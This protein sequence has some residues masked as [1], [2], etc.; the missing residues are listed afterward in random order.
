[1]KIVSGVIISLIGVYSASLYADNNAKF[2]QCAV[3]LCGPTSRYAR[4][5]ARG[6]FSSMD[7]ESKTYWDREIA[8]QMK[9][10]LESSL[11]QKLELFEIVDQKLKTG[12]PLN[13][14]Q[15]AMLSVMVARARTRKVI[16]ECL[17]ST[18]GHDYQVSPTKLQ[19]KMP[20]LK[21]QEVTDLTNVLNAYLSSQYFKMARNISSFKYDLLL[22]TLGRLASFQLA[23]VQNE[24][25]KMNEEV[26][27]FASTHINFELLE[28]MVA[29]QPLSASE[30]IEA[31]KTL[32]SVYRMAAML[33]PKVQAVVSKLDLNIKK[34]AENMA[35]DANYKTV[36]S[37]LSS[38]EKIRQEKEKILSYCQEA[39]VKSLAA[40]PSALRQRKSNEL[41]EQVKI[42]ARAIAPQYFSGEALAK[43][44]ATLQN[45]K[46]T[47]P[48]SVS[49]VKNENRALINQ[50]L[51]VLNR[52]A[53]LIEKSLKDNKLEPSMVLFSLQFIDSVKQDTF[54]NLKD[55]CDMIAP[56]MFEDSAIGTDTVITSWQ[57]NMFPEI[58]VGVLA[59][60][61]GHSLSF[62]LAGVQ[63]TGAYEATRTCAANSHAKLLGR[64][65]VDAFKQF[66]EEDWAD[67]FAATTLNHLQKS[68]PYTENYACALVAI[69]DNA[70]GEPYTRLELFDERNVD[71]HSSSLLRA[72]QMQVALGKPLP[73]SCQNAMNENERAIIGKVCGK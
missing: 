24:A 42:S 62:A 31:I 27:S 14:A 72:L 43:V 35:W 44:E 55:T 3:D 33:D 34:A 38:P 41:L 32:E 5:T 10:I 50:N 37:R 67:S 73:K 15:K 46:F 61:M 13:D 30:K 36:K 28:R 17:I 51:R 48:R 49:E 63:G 25:K 64:T 21:P 8:P 29:L 60:E 40:A 2:Q 16:E 47:Q 56:P 68:W 58:G 57:S 19:E 52:T 12:M 70:A 23:Q 7:R 45:I 71:V 53:A 9:N 11:R 18:N 65:D 22:K 66:Q 39:I 54:T 59:H 20:E 6:A 69:D 26:G 1:M 4:I